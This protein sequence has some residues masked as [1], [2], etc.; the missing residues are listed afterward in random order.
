MTTE[1][2]LDLGSLSASTVLLLFV[3]GRLLWCRFG[4]NLYS[5]K[6]NPPFAGSGNSAGGGYTQ[7]TKPAPSAK[8]VLGGIGLTLGWWVITIVDRLGL[9][10]YDT[11]VDARG[12]PKPLSML[13][14]PAKT[15]EDNIRSISEVHVD[16]WLPWACTMLVRVFKLLNHKPGATLPASGL[17]FQLQERAFSDVRARLLGIRRAQHFRD[18]AGIQGAD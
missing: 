8:K 18:H 13:E 2:I 17:G 3:A 1:S 15:F 11:S 5:C 4:R 14:H 10:W 6:P 12:V 7:G 9:S 16:R